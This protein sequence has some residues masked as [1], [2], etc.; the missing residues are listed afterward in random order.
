MSKLALPRFLAIFMVL[1]IGA[2]AVMPA[3]A[4]PG[5]TP[6][7]ILV[8]QSAPLSGPSANLGMEMRDGALA[9]FD[10]VNSQGGVNG[11]KIVLKTLDD[12][13]DAERAASNTAQLIDSDGVF[14]LFGYVGIGPSKAALPL[15]EKS[16][17]PFFAPLTGGEFLHTRFHANVFNIRAGNSLEMEKIVENLQGMG[18]KKIA[19]LHNNDVAGRAALGEFERALQ[20]RKLTVMGTATVER[21]STDVAAAVVKM[22]AMA[23]HAVL[24]IT[25]YPASAAFIRA[26]RK[27][28]LSLPFFWN[29]SFVGSQALVAALGK[30]APGVMISQV[31]PSP[32]NA[33]MALV[34]EYKQLYLS[35]PGRQQGFSSLEGF[36]A[37]KAFVKGLERGSTNV[38]RATFRKGLESMSSVDLGGFFLKF[39]PTN[40]E[41]SDYV[42]LTVVRRDGTFVY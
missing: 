19:V 33:R 4:A 12:G 23:P 3:H 39:S 28:A 24:M 13:A 6:D 37:A 26:M 42:E 41:A 14:A 5:V 30:E 21:N 35:K 7:G 1:S 18:S 11:R 2:T 8:G 27:D 10:H 9:W 29:M 40:H 38:N 25:S 31:M 36:I 34:K 16:D 15:V 20:K 32:W 22:R 17:V